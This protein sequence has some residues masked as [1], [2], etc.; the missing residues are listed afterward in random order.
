M[1]EP[2]RNQREE[3]PIRVLLVD[4]DE[5][6]RKALKR[7]LGASQGIVV[8]GTAADGVEALNAAERLNPDVVLMDVKMPRMDG[9]EA[10][11]KLLGRLPCVKV[12]ALSGFSDKELVDGMLKAGAVGYLDKLSPSEEIAKAILRAARG[13]C[14]LGPGA[15]AVLVAEK[16][17]GAQQA[18]A[19][20]VPVADAPTIDATSGLTSREQEILRMIADGQGRR[21][22]AFALCVSPKT[23]DAHRENILAKLDLGS[24]AELLRYA[25]RTGILPR[26]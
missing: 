14:C 25:L 15:S 11:R 10:T 1:N 18:T 16:R 8:V 6:V 19:P 9:I 21:R 7:V 13:E 4:D 24:T 26:K 20:I 23:V 17:R 22:I 12:L 2:R 3:T 5:R